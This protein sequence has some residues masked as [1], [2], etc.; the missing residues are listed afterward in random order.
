MVVLQKKTQQFNNYSSLKQIFGIFISILTLLYLLLNLT[1]GTIE[2]NLHQKAHNLRQ[3]AKNVIVTTKYKTPKRLMNL[4]RDDM[5]VGD[6]LI[7][8][9]SG[10]LTIEEAIAVDKEHGLGSKVGAKNKKSP[11]KISEILDF[12]SNFLHE[13]HLICVAKKKATYQDIWDAYHDLA[14]K[15]LYPWD[16]E[17]L[18]RMPERRFDDTI[19]LSLASYRDENC[20][21]TITNAFGKSKNPEK[22]FI[23]LV[24]QNCE[25]H[26][27]SGVLEGGK[28]IVC[29]NKQSSFV[30]QNLPCTCLQQKL[31]NCSTLI[32][33]G[34]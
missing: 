27:R 28:M 17:Y 4:L 18:K 19:F 13:L 6:K 20:V 25:E 29:Q 15:T 1:K 22:L 9:Q 5:I 8:I 10:T 7:K 32:F 14:V 33:E 31:M 2:D 16:K 26:C 3:V 11:M 21:S 34:C 30:L 23:G 12:F 24:Q